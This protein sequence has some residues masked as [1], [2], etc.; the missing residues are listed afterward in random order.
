MRALALVSARRG[1]DKKFPKVHPGRHM[2]PLGRFLS[3]LMELSTLSHL[4]Y[5]RHV[6]S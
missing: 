2:F 4:F 1:R 5:L 3:L 6:L